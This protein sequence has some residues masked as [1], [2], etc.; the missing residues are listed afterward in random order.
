M[1]LVLH[2]QTL[3]C[4]FLFEIESPKS[5]AFRVVVGHE[6][7]SLKELQQQT[8][9]LA[10]VLLVEYQQQ[11]LEYLDHLNRAL[12]QFWILFHVKGQN[13]LQ[14]VQPPFD[15]RLVPQ[16]AQYEQHRLSLKSGPVLSQQYIDLYC[17]DSLG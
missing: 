8:V 15:H 12:D 4:F 2:S 11:L 5:V 10:P 13:V 9:S 6:V 16:L 14:R 3:L 17:D 1:L 7:E